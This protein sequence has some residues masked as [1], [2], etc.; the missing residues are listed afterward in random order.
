MRWFPAPAGTARG[1][2]LIV[3]GLGEHSGRYDHVAAKLR[4]WGWA[5]AS[6]DHRGHGLSEG[7]R[8]RLNRADDLLTDLALVLDTV[9]ANSPAPLVLLGHS[10]GGQVAAQFVAESIRPVDALVLSSPALD[11]GLTRSRA[12]QLAIAHA[13]ASNFAVPSGLLPRYTSHDPES[14]RRYMVDP[15]VHGIVTAKLVRSIVDGGRRARAMANRWTVP[16]L[17]MYA[18]DDKLVNAAGSAEFAANAPPSVV[19]SRRFDGLYHEIFN[20]VEKEKV[21][22]VLREWLDER[23]P[24]GARSAA[25]TAGALARPAS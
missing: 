16:T 24:V 9:R 21:F 17:L 8:G 15:L 12:L 18:G 22:D 4:S 5:V 3:H 20:E 14:V 10:M 1:T 7:K 19:R 25:P 6:Y 11:A 2:V 13:L 23:F